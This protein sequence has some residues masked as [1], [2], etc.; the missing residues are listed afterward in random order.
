M[1]EVSP[2]RKLN[3]SIRI[4]LLRIL[5]LR[6]LDLNDTIN[7]FDFEMQFTLP[8]QGSS[9]CGHDIVV[10][11]HGQERT[12]HLRQVA[13]HSVQGTRKGTCA[14]GR[15]R[16]CWAKERPS[17]GHATTNDIIMVLSSI[18]SISWRWGKNGVVLIVVGRRKSHRS[19]SSVVLL[20]T[21][22]TAQE[23]CENLARLEARFCSTLLSSKALHL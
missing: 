1:L 22:C 4:I 11:I 8:L 20:L 3:H 5:S 6:I 13:M 9:C 14:L 23:R 2:R 15:A 19:G 7:P 16:T 18:V 10:D 21:L 12:G 17:L